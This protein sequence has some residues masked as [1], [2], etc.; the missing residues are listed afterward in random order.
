MKRAGPAQQRHFAEHTHGT[1]TYPHL[2]VSQQ[3][4]KRPEGRSHSRASPG[5]AASR[6]GPGP[7][8][9]QHLWLPAASRAATGLSAARTLLRCS[10]ITHTLPPAPTQQHSRSYCNSEQI[11]QVLLP[12]LRDPPHCH[13]VMGSKAAFKS[14]NL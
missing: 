5:R 2:G 12:P 11:H 3:T 1:H 8:D 6:P 9:A 14:Q 13:G 7:T 4:C 10:L